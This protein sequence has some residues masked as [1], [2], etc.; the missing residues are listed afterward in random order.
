[1][2][3][4]IYTHIIKTLLIIEIITNLINTINN[5]LNNNQII[6]KLLVKDTF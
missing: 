2:K 4:Y 3:I 5:E 6:I 1:M